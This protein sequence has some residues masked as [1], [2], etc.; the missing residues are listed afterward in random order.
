QK[1]IAA[2]LATLSPSNPSSEQAKLLGWDQIYYMQVDEQGGNTIFPLGK[3]T[4][5]LLVAQ[6]HVAEFSQ[7]QIAAALQGALE[8]EALK[9][10]LEEGYYQLD[11]TSNYW[12]DT[13]LTAQYFGLE[14][15]YFSSATVDPVGN[16]TQYS[17]DPH[18]LLLNQVTDALQNTVK[19]QAIDYQHL[20]PMQLIDVNENTSEVKLD[21]LGRVVYTSH[22]GH[23]AGQAKGFVPLSQAPTV[24]PSTLQDVI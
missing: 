24:I 6:Q 5:P 17:Y 3:V 10:K 22:Y 15:F 14:K 16:Q 19:S 9:Q 12:W 2:A 13:G 7:E 20:H 4:L 11:T 23:E 8:G 1:D 18:Y 21:P